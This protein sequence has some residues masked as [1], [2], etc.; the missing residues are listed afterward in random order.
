VPF[1]PAVVPPHAKIEALFVAPGVKVVKLPGVVSV[2]VT[3]FVAE[4][5]LR[6][7][8]AGQAF[9]AAARLVARVLLLA[10]VAK[11]P[12]VELPQVLVP[13]EPPLTAPQLK[14]VPRFEP[15]TA[16]KGP[17]VPLVIVNVLP[18]TYA[19]VTPTVAAVQRL[20]AELMLLATS[21]V[22]AAVAKVPAVELPQA[23]LPLLPAVTALHAKLLAVP[24]RVVSVD[25]VPMVP[26]VTVTT[27]PA[28]L[29]VTPIGKVVWQLVLLIAAAKFAAT[30]AGVV[31]TVN[32]P[33]VALLHALLTL[34]AGMVAAGFKVI[35][36]VELSL[37]ATVPA[38][39]LVT[40][41]TAPA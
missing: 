40:V 41:T 2:T 6:P 3:V 16:R 19:E 31:F 1:V 13:A 15:P 29:A 38:V 18:D 4:T 27:A 26:S 28:T 7:A 39:M 17:G 5:A 32:V 37:H 12:D 22:V 14:R 36:V 34:P 30:V 21:A 23:L 20:I 10:L 25:A 8:P 9:N 33:A 35:A 11:V 24:P